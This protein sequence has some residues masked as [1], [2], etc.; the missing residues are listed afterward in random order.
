MRGLLQAPKRASTLKCGQGELWTARDRCL[1]MLSMP[2]HLLGE[3]RLI[4]L[5][6]VINSPTS[7]CELE[8]REKVSFSF[9]TFDCRA[10]RALE[11]GTRRVLT[12]PSRF[13]G[14]S[15]MAHQLWRSGCHMPGG[16]QTA[17]K[18]ILHWA[19]GLLQDGTCRL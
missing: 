7:P 13:F 10:N 15:R 11:V 8:A 2:R 19:H 17:R 18:P 12:V 9:L 14:P 3:G 6:Y 1:L 16:S 5:F 4:E